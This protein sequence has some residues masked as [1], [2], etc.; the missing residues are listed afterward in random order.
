MDAVGKVYGLI[1]GQTAS[2]FIM[3]N[4]G[5]PV[6]DVCRPERRSRNKLHVRKRAVL[7]GGRKIKEV[8]L[9][10]RSDCGLRKL[11]VCVVLGLVCGSRFV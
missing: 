10:S 8:K 7:F 11:L 2:V 1:R 5:G 3:M 6:G 4:A 9:E